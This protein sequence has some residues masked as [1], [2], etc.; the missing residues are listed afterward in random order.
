MLFFAL[1]GFAEEAPQPPCGPEAIATYPEADAVP[2]VQSWRNPNLVR[3]WQPPACTGWSGT[4]YG[5]LVTTAARFHS[6]AQAADML[7]R[8]GAISQLA[9][10]RYWSTTHKKWQT[11]IEEAHPLT[12]VKSSQRRED[13]TVEELKTHDPRY[14][15][16][17]DN[18]AGRATYRLHVGTSSATRIVFDLENLNTV[19]YLL[20]TLFHPGDLQSIYFLDRES[21]DVWRYYSIVRIGKNA[22][23][24]VAGN[25]SSTINRAVAFFR[26]LAGIPSE[27]EPPAA[28]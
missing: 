22:S 18:L 3:A 10:M 1:S 16:Q 12:G 25:D 24:L 2:I 20:L 8:I 23:G 15:E 6:A 19:R 17:V 14:F 27:R 21:E 5:A 13:F 9:G 28:P 4:G 7:G 11:L 26:H